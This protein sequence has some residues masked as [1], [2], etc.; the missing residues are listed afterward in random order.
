LL[1]QADVPCE[2]RDVDGDELNDANEVFLTNSQFGVLAVR[3]IDAR[4][5]SVGTV[6][7]QIQDLLCADGVPECSV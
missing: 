2:V 6:T 1:Q 3:A 4:Q 7:R 5:L